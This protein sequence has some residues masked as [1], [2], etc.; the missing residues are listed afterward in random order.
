MLPDLI[1]LALFVRAVEFNSLS[2]AAEQ[3]H[4]GA[5]SG[6]CAQ[7]ALYLMAK[8]QGVDYTKLNIVNLPAPLFRNSFMSNSID[9]GI[10]WSPYSYMLD[11]EGYRVVNWDTDYVPAGGVCPRTTAVRP[12]FLKSHPEIGAKLLQVDAM[13]SD[14]IAKNP[15]LAVDALVKRLGLTPA[16]AKASYERLYLNRPTIAQQLDPTSPY[17]MTSKNGGLAAQY[18]LATQVLYE[19][20]AIP[21][22][23]PLSAIQEAIDPG[24]PQQFA[25]QRGK[26]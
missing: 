23:V 21:A 22:P 25:T 2:N 1:S 24:P 14:A 6:T 26:P 15:Q 16:V 18:L 13:A 12:A 19:T 4:I 3:S 7:I 8:K 9:A 5:A 10:A 17:S 20:K 11:A